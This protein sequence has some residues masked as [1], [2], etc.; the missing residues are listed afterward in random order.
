VDKFLANNNVLRIVA[1]ILSCILW[2]A[3]QPSPDSG[4]VTTDTG[5]SKFP[6]AVHVEAPDD[7]VVT[8]VEP[9]TAIIVVHDSVLGVQALAEQMLNVELVAD[10]RGLGPGSH[11]V[12]L[13]AVHMPPVQYEIDPSTVTVQISDRATTTRP[14]HVVVRGNPA[15]GYSVGQATCDV[16]NVQVTGARQVLD[17]VASVAAYVSV[18]GA[19]KDVSAQVSL[20]AVD[21]RGNPVTGVTLSPTTAN[22]SVPIVAPHRQVRL[23]LE[24]TGTPAAGYDVAGLTVEPNTVTLYGTNLPA[25]VTLPVDVSR[26]NRTRTLQLKVQLP[27]GAVQ[28]EPAV[29]AVKVRLESSA[30][31]SF[32]VPIVIRNSPAGE[33]VALTD[34]TQVS[35]QISGPQSQVKRLT[36]DDVKAYIDAKELKPGDKKANVQVD[37]PDG[38]KVTQLSDARVAVKVTK[39]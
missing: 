11:D 29:V 20:A 13:Q 31:K 35:V 24:V 32:T 30:T 14:V 6:V 36:A 21:A 10:V 4:A 38:I 22:V 7:T 18:Q 2:F 25:T 19:T 27:D 3:V 8:R 16:Q 9:S 34:K 39:P 5:V 37:V 12:P 17:R 26:L 33:T 1:I 23:R 15:T 28:A